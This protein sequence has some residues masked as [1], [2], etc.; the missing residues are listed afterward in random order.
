MLSMMARRKLRCF[1]SLFGCHAK[2]WR[3]SIKRE[4]QRV[5]MRLLG[6]IGLAR[7]SR[8]AHGQAKGCDTSA[9]GWNPLIAPR[10]RAAVC[11]DKRQLAALHS[12]AVTRIAMSSG[13]ALSRQ[14]RFLVLA[15]G[16]VI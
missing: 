9:F 2:R 6:P 15:G 3:F 5:T 14:W 16:E 8:A 13:D 12:R 11:A 10:P 1:S 7:R 4:F